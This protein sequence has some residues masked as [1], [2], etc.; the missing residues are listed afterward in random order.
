MPALVLGD[1]VAVA[2]AA[3]MLAL[4][5]LMLGFGTALLRVS[6]LRRDGQDTRRLAGLASALALLGLATWAV[7]ESRLL[8]D[9]ANGSSTVSV[10]VALPRIGFGQV[11]LVQAA[12]TL[13]AAL[14]VTFGG[15][16]LAVV[17]SAAA[18]GA[19]AWHLHAVAME[20]GISA[21]LVSEVLHVLAAGAWLG[22]LPALMLA[23]RAAP[24]A[25]AAR[26]ARG[27]SPL[28]GGA[29]LVLAGTAIWQGWVLVG[30]LPGLV[31]TAYGWLVLAKAGLF[32]GLLACAALNR[33]SLVLA[34][35]GGGAGSARRRL[36]RNVGVETLLGVLAVGVAAVLTTQQPGMHTQ[37]VWPFAVRPSLSIV[38]AD[39]AFRQE[40]QDA[41]L[42][43]LGALALVGLGFW[44]S[45]MRWLRWAAWAAAAAIA[46]FAVPH[47][48]LLF[49][50]AYPTSFYHSPTRFAATSIV[51]GEALYPQYCASC[52]G[53][54]GRGDGAAAKGMRIP[55]ADLTAEHLWGHDDGELF[56]W[57]TQGIRAGD[58]EQVMPG[59]GAVLSEE[60]RWALI[61]FVRAR[62]AGL[63]A[64]VAGTWSPPLQAPAF[65]AECADGHELALS[66][67]RGRVAV[68]ALSAGSV[69]LGGAGTAPACASDDPAV[70][71]TYALVTGRDPA[72]IVGMAVL[73]DANGWLRGVFA[74]AETVK[75][76]A[77]VEAIAKDPLPEEASEHHHMMM[78]E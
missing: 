50:E 27:F 17:A 54:S 61:D 72:T 7:V 29:V 23:I 35:D 47:L 45:W 74:A 43:L 5:G 76:A 63:V 1:G 40:V 24:L 16:W 59:F 10:L 34:M 46:W 55:P 20:P 52:H 28:G 53:A 68:V 19:Q 6:L 44:V 8:A 32:L 71:T 48:D 58:G 64:H 33:L 31:G 41:V 14:A 62:N 75:I 3:R 39:P 77:T 12:A 11:L 56:W 37:P 70:P 51:A 21:L 69:T 15:W 78:S 73:V 36:V 49:I 13:L 67:L 42:A 22:A 4:A 9:R 65:D 66:D 57:L 38:R 26:L 30:G 25:D 18:L 60:Q 2:A